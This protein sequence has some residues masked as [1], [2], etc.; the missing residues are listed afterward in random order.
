MN[1]LE[2]L[3]KDV[4]SAIEA[5][6]PQLPK[7]LRY[8]GQH[9][10]DNRDR[11]IFQ[12]IRQLASEAKVSEATI[13]RFSSLLGFEGYSDL[14]AAARD[15]VIGRLSAAQP[16]QDGPVDPFRELLAE[17]KS[18]VVFTELVGLIGFA[19]KVHILASPEV[20][21]EATRL[22]WNLSRLRPGVMVASET[23]EWA[24]EE[25][26]AL[27]RDSVVVVMTNWHST[28]ELLA[29]TERVREKK[30]PQYLISLNQASAL[31][32]FCERRVVLREP[33]QYQ[34]LALTL[35][36]NLLAELSKPALLQ[37]HQD[38]SERLER[39]ALKRQP[40]SERRDTLQLA[41][42]HEIRTLDP[43][44]IH[45]LMREA[46]VMRCVFQGLVRFKE[47]TFEVVPELAESWQVSD[48]GH[49]IVF[50]LRPGVYFH[51]GFGE[52]TALDVKFS[53]ERMT[54]PL[55]LR[56]QPAWEDLEEV[57]VLGRY[58]VKLI[59]RHPSPHL[60]TSI[61][62]MSTG[63]IVSRKALERMGHSQYSTNP[64][65]TGPYA[66]TSFNPR[67]TLEMESFAQFW[68]PP[69]K[70]S[71]LVF[72]LDVHAFNF[73]YHFKKGRLDA[74]IFPNVSPQMF[75]D[76]PGLKLDTRKALQFWWLGLSTDQPPFD[77]LEVRQAVRLAL[78]Q[79]KIVETGLPGTEPL[80]TVIPKGVP[81]HWG[82]APIFP[83]SP[84]EARRLLAEAGVA[85]G[86][87]IHLGADPSEVD[88]AVLEIVRANLVDI[89]FDVNFEMS[90]RKLLM[91]KI[92]R[93]QC[94][95]YLFFYNAH[96]D[97]YLSLRW[98][99]KDQLYNFSHWDNPAYE[100]LVSLIGREKNETKRL[101]MI[102]EA[103]K[104]IIDDAWAVWLAQGHNTIIHNDY[105]DIGRP[106]P[107]GFLTPWTM[108]KNL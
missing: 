69:P 95:L 43:C 82:E 17:L 35:A 94:N 3:R 90:N 58:I 59:F 2:P 71:R 70:T 27:P 101:E 41:I 8:L 22:K 96:Q 38:Y 65:G 81:G 62:P 97:A 89:G 21:S 15:L 1:I 39:V 16:S 51:H 106:L 10:L 66:V 93:R 50:Y 5:E 9:I 19:P 85:K 24:E 23:A 36:V 37:R 87:K 92:T 46:M 26:E 56:R 88:F 55:V 86:A 4:F 80:H 48:D 99:V 61:L 103:Q 72:R 32:E 91:E 14:Q 54:D 12:T 76:L 84:A 74:A 40:L 100:K 67:E 45:S 7:K 44:S 63:L 47:G 34:G 6:L 29:L 33:P 60:F 18:D 64:I 57:V 79:R 25:I 52:F 104:L 83:Y 49:S 102:V 11:V 98:F 31:A 28:L 42:G 77:R 78:D 108:R 68:G 105:V 53:F 73:P 30:I 13:M 75:R 20:A 107:D